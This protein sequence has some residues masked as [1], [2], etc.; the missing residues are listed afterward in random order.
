MWQGR[1]LTDVPMI[2][3][4]VPTS[5]CLRKHPTQICNKATK[6]QIWTSAQVLIGWIRVL[7]QTC[8]LEELPNFHVFL[9]LFYIETC[10]SWWCIQI[11]ATIWQCACFPCILLGWLVEISSVQHFTELFCNYMQK[12]VYHV[13]VVTSCCVNKSMLL[14]LFRSVWGGMILVPM[15]RILRNGHSEVE[16]M[17]A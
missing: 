16:L 3:C 4:M 11:S 5:L 17:E 2:S 13:P 7:R 1:T 6:A 12:Q 9:P 8:T 10:F 14:T 15:T